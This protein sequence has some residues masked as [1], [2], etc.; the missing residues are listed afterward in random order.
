MVRSTF[1]SLFLFPAP[2]GSAADEEYQ[3]AVIA[4]AKWHRVTPSASAGTASK[5]VVQ[6]ASSS[7]SG[8]AKP[9]NN[10]SG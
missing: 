6:D 4:T 7:S 3:Q 5:V 10:N 8:Q 1:G 2:Q 9:A